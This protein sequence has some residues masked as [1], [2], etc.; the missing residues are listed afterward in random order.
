MQSG[1][2]NLPTVNGIMQSAG[3]EFAAR[4]V[5]HEAGD[6]GAEFSAD[7]AAAYPAE[8]GIESWKRTLRLDRRKNSVTVTDAYRLKKAGGTIALTLMTPR[9]VTQTGPGELA[10]Q[11]ALKVA[12]PAALRVKTEEVSTRDPRLRAVWGERIYRVLLTQEKAPASGELALTILQAK[13]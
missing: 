1:Y 4:G 9:P 11:G 7:I 12:Y 13:A 5:T 10:F 2:H 6:G 3:R 8:A